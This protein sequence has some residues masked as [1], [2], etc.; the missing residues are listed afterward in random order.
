MCVCVCACMC[1]CV[2]GCVERLEVSRQLAV[3]IAV[4]PL[5]CADLLV[6][7]LRSQ[8]LKTKTEFPMSCLTTAGRVKQEFRPVFQPQSRS[9]TGTA[10]V[11]TTLLCKQFQRQNPKDYFFAEGIKSFLNQ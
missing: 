4:V 11:N 3:S 8:L 1:V 9:K 2:C 6:G 5:N 7:K 10:N